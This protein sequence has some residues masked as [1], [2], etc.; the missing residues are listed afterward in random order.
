MQFLVMLCAVIAAVDN[1]A[2]LLRMSAAVPGN[3]Y[4]LG[5][6]EAPP[7]IISV[8]LGEQLTSILSELADG[9]HPNRLARTELYTGVPTIPPLKRDDSCLLYT[10]RPPP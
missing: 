10:S 9:H 8:F 3:D 7:A 5:A 1:H 6:S 4:R 2:D